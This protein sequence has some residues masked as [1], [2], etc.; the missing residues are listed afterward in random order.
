MTRRLFHILI[1][2]PLLLAA[3][4]LGETAPEIPGSG[5][6]ITVRCEDP[7]QTK[8]DPADGELRFNENL[9][10]AVDFFFY[11]GSAPAGTADAVYHHRVD[12]DEDPVSYTGGQWEATFSIVLRRADA[13][14]IFTAANGMQA[15]VYAIVNYAADLTPGASLDATSMD[16]LAAVAVETD[17]AA[18][19]SQYLQGSFLMDGKTV[20]TYNEAASISASGTIDARRFAAKMTTAV[21]VANQVTLKH[22]NST[23]D[24]DEVWEPVLHTMR[25]YLVDP[26]P[27][28]QSPIPNPQSPI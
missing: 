28:P 4:C 23:D 15:T 26:I 7:A 5:V 22:V 27:N 18:T 17:F 2:L 9:I 24:P 6:V 10:R 14:Q 16:E 11:P 21:S 25:I 19:E 1:L 13:E 8:A 3:G 20:I 12:L